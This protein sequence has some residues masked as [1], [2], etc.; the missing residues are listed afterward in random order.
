MS[1]QAEEVAA[2]AQELAQ[3]AQQLQ[4]LVAQ[5]RFGKAK[6]WNQDDRQTLKSAKTRP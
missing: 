1:A 2:S 3:V 6:L 4:T 5:F